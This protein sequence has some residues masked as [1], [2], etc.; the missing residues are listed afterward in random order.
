[1]E[2]LHPGANF[3]HLLD[4]GIIPDPV[5]QPGLTV[6]EYLD[7][8]YPDNLEERLTDGKGRLYSFKYSINPVTFLQM[9]M[10][11]YFLAF[12]AITVTIDC[13]NNTVICIKESAR[14]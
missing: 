12:G 14:C 8:L 4:Q 7:S 11:Q 5:R 13:H 9:E 3:W 10:V 6:S 2:H 1:M